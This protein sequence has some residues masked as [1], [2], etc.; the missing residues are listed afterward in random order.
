E[1]IIKLIRE[2][3]NTLDA[4]IR[5]ILDYSRNSRRTLNLQWVNLKKIVEEV[6]EELTYMKGFDRLH[7]DSDIDPAF[8]VITDRDRLKVVLNNLV[9]N[10]VKYS[11]YGKNSFIKISASRE[12]NHWGITIEDNGIGIKPEH[13]ERIFDMFY[14]A[15]DHSQGTGLGLYIVKETIQRLSGEILMNSTYGTGTR[16]SIILP[17]HPVAEDSGK[18]LAEL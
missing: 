1:S 3:A 16:F 8:E 4:F 18:V 2:R 7:L 9:A 15:H 11:D 5:E 6:L 10:A 13:H 12:S 14:Q 17:T